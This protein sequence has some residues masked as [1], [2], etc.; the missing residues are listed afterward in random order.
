[1]T[2]KKITK[3]D[4]FGLSALLWIHRREDAG[5]IVGRKEVNDGEKRAIV[6]SS[7][8]CRN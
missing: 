3:H 7:M 4:G 8:S 6:L 5:D 1:M 2:D